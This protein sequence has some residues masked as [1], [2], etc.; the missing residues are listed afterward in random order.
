MCEALGSIPWL[1]YS[2]EMRI[3]TPT[4]SVSVPRNTAG[5]V[6]VRQIFSYF[7]EHTYPET[8]FRRVVALPN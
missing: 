2:G 5:P 6:L 4:A 1:L 8:A 7:G 3:A